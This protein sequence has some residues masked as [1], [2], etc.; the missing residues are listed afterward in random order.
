MDALIR[1]HHAFTWKERIGILLLIGGGAG[2]AVVAI[3]FGV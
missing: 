3:W 1:L 2:R